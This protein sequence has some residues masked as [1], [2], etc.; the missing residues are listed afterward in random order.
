MTIPYGFRVIRPSLQA[1]G[2]LNLIEVQTDRPFPY[3]VE[4]ECPGIDHPPNLP[5]ADSQFFGELWNL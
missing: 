5:R 1:N 2:S 4:W 3:F